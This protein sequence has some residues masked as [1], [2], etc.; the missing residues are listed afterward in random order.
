MNADGCSFEHLKRI[1]E[2]LKKRGV[3][4]K[5]KDMY[6]RTALHYAVISQCLQLVNM[7]V[8][9]HTIT[10]LTFTESRV[11]DYNI[12]EIDIDGHSPFSYCLRGKRGSL[13]LYNRAF[14]MQNIFY[15][16]VKN[17]ADVNIVYP[18]EI[19]K[20]YHK[21]EELLQK[22]SGSYDKKVYKCSPLINIIR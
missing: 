18:E 17:G 13:G 14:P 6:H 22:F 12:N 8:C 19:Y 9:G 5:A 2:T 21:D 15:T 3:D 4:V 16:L 11:S 10:N 1:Y 7:L 20:P